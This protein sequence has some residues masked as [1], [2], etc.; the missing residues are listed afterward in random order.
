MY[1]R[2]GDRYRGGSAHELALLAAVVFSAGSQISG[3]V[4]FL[5]MALDRRA[6]FTNLFDGASLVWSLEPDLRRLAF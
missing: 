4:T 3:W 2:G 5:P 1:T 6:D